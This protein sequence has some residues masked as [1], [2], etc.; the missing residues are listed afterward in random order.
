[1]KV[2]TLKSLRADQDLKH[3]AGKVRFGL[4]GKHARLK[5]LLRRDERRKMKQQLRATAETSDQERTAM[6]NLGDLLKKKGFAASPPKDRYYMIDATWEGAKSNFPDASAAAVRAMTTATKDMNRAIGSLFP[7]AVGLCGYAWTDGSLT[8]YLQVRAASAKTPEDLHTL[9]RQK[10]SATR[11][12]LTQDAT[13]VPPEHILSPDGLTLA[14]L[15]AGTRGCEFCA[16][17]GYIPEFIDEKD[18]LREEPKKI[19]CA[20]CKGTGRLP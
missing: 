1:M 14:S 5:R 17:L 15:F 4:R 19:V 7:D 18:E 13:E 16:E 8:Y 10:L 6:L 9:L 3:L 20:E 12:R 11:T 2:K